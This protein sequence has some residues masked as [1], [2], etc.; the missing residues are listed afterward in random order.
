MERTLVWK[1]WHTPGVENLRLSRNASGIHATSHLMEVIKGDSIAASYL[2]DC[3]QHWQF[4][5]LWIKVENHGQRSLCLRR[6]EQ[7]N[8]LLDGVPRPDLQGC[9]HVMLSASPFT[10]TPI[11]QCCRLQA[12]QS[13]ELRVVYIDLLTLQIEPRLQRYECLSQ[14]PDENLYYSQTEGCLDEELEV[15]GQ[16]LLVNSNE[17]YMCLSQRDLKLSE[18][19]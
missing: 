1:P 10:H 13:E 18:L 15:D 5:R 2:I 6:D 17:R 8:W 9:Q 19:A 4:R 7:G 11:L 16:T 12:K 14:S 3:D